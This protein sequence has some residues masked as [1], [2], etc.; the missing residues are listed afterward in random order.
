MIDYLHHTAV[1]SRV[2]EEGSFTLA[3]CGQRSLIGSV[4]F[5]CLLTF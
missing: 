4:W 5:Q 3:A 2:A 1:F